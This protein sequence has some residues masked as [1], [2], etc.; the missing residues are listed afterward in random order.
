[1]FVPREQPTR[2]PPAHV[3]VCPTVAPSQSATQ[4]Q[5]VC[6]SLPVMGL[7]E[8]LCSLEVHQEEMGTRR[9]PTPRVLGF[10]VQPH[11]REGS[12][13]VWKQPDPGVR[14]TSREAGKAPAPQAWILSAPLHMRVQLSGLG[15][16][17]PLGEVLVTMFCFRKGGK[18]MKLEPP[19]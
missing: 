9:S 17:P 18:C 10:C 12:A 13:A 2:C 16:L 11:P 7:L 15:P 14:L 1:M 5:C 4:S 3:G 19:F 6:P 8:S